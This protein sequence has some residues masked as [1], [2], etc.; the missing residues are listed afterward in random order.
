M[1]NNSKNE[2]TT[3]G[4][5]AAQHHTGTMV[6]SIPEK[7]S[8]INAKDFRLNQRSPNAEKEHRQGSSS[9]GS[10]HGF[11]GTEIDG[12][13]F[14]FNGNAAGD[15]PKQGGPSIHIMRNCTVS[16]NSVLFN[17]DMDPES[18]RKMFCKAR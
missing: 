18:F 14:A 1:D 17:G 11:S 12:S 6:R 7:A 3:C 16:N 10:V 8:P 2:E 4:G 5:H 9:T 15:I 13:S